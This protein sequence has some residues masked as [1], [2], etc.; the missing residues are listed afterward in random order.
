MPETTQANLEQHVASL[1]AHL[2]QENPDL[3]EVVRGFRRLDK[4]AY[5]LGLLEPTESTRR[6]S[7]GGR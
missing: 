2:E 7:P 3:L 1:V 4:V 6:R 5:K